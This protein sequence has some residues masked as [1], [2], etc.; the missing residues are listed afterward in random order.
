[1]N[2][3]VRIQNLSERWQFTARR[4]Q[5]RAGFDGTVA[6]PNFRD[7]LAKRIERELFGPG[8]APGQMALGIGKG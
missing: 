1:M 8:G 2:E 3:R 6:Q 4:E 5:D 7:D